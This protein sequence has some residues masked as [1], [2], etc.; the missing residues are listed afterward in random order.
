MTDIL[1]IDMETRSRADLKKVGPHRYAADPSTEILM[2]AIALNDETPVLWVNPKYRL[3]GGIM[4]SCK[5]ADEL[6]EM[7]HSCQIYAHNMMFEE[8]ML[9][10]RGAEDLRV[11]MPPTDNLRCTLAMARRAAL[12]LSLKLLAE[13]LGVSGKDEAGRDFI[14]MFS[15]P[16][17]SGEFADP[18]TNP[19]EWEGFGRYCIQDVVAEQGIHRELKAFEFRGSL[20]RTWQFDRVMNHTGVP[21][22]VTALRNAEKILAEA[23]TKAV[24]EFRELTGLNPT[25][26]D[27]VLAWL[28]ERGYGP[29][30]LEA[31]EV[32]EMLENEH[33]KT[34]YPVA[35]R[36]LELRKYTSFAAV[37]KIR[38][39]LDCQIDGRVYGTMNFYGAGPG[40]WTAALI[41]PQNFKRATLDCTDEIY[42][43]ICKGCSTQ[44]LELLYGNPIEAIA[45]SIRHFIHVPGQ[46]MYDAD[47]SAIEARI[48][49]WL[50]G[51]ED[52]LEAYRK[53]EDAYVKMAA[54]IF[55]KKEKEISK[56]ERWLGKQTVLGCGFSMGAQKFF[57]QCQTLARKFKIK[58]INVTEE[59]ATKSVTAYRE[60]YAKVKELWYSC[61]RAAR[62]AILNPGKRFAA[63]PK[64][65]FFVYRIGKIDFLIMRLPSS[66]SIVYPWPK[67]EVCGP[68]D[69]RPVITFFG[70]LP[71]QPNKWGRIKTYG[72]KL[73]ENATQGTAA[74]C[75]GHGAANAMDAGFEIPMLVHDQ[76]LAMEEE[77]L[78]L[79]QFVNA[80]TSMP[81]W[82][83][84]LP[85]A[86]EGDVVPYYK[87]L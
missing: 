66:R 28:R 27:K 19:V 35:Y 86:A 17:K 64:L 14:R 30:S 85:L 78:S 59:L 26:R 81:E 1:H 9:R 69:D 84:G 83:D 75:M 16:K 32:D 6:V 60:R 4:A 42:D 22:N 47:Y 2:M 13:T 23:E 7:L 55:S 74:D 58:G 80:L 18:H 25:Q 31:V 5:R 3:K 87:K 63:G 53:N 67:L 46:S 68:D 77:K 54:L 33:F 29:E 57:D 20:L 62:N 36:A 76:A 70:E 49:C 41:Q 82:A 79:D 37:K 56:M 24:A 38:T 39:M 72:G 73:V 61:D 34:N 43:M 15:L 44:D 71:K 65:S 40:R 10:W 45:S 50:A 8:A 52:A 11:M 12:P 21:V 48:V 51:Q